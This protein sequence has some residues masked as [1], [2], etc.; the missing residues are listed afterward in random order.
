MDVGSPALAG[1]GTKKA[2]R[3][4]APKESA[5]EVDPAEANSRFARALGDLFYSLGSYRYVPP[6]FETECARTA[7]AE[8]VR[9]V[10]PARRPLYR[11]RYLRRLRVMTIRRKVILL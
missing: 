2:V 3:P 10:R 6:G 5:T 11:E 9:P 1:A 8:V 4:A 7:R